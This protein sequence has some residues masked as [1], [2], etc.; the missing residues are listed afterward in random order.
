MS[1]NACVSF[2]DNYFGQEWIHL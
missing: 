2:L 1:Q